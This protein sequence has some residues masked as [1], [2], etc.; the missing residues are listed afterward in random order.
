MFRLACRP[1]IVVAHDRFRQ[2]DFCTEHHRQ[3][4]VGA[5]LT[6][7]VHHDIG[8]R[9]RGCFALRNDLCDLSGTNGFCQNALYCT[10]MSQRVFAAKAGSRGAFNGTFAGT[11]ERA[12]LI[13]K[14]ADASVQRF[15]KR[16][17]IGVGGKFGAFHGMID[18]AHL[19]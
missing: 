9:L 12:T 3:P 14:A 5:D 10:P 17:L 2:I 8:G 16:Y 6:K 13:E 15:G 1:G 4:P 18:K 7:F 19:D 11:S